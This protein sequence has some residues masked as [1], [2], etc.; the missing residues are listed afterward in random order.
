[1]LQLFPDR[2]QAG[3]D[4][5]RVDGRAQHP[6]AQQALAHGGSSRVD[7]TEQSDSNISARVQRLDQLEVADS[8]GIENQAVLALVEADAVHMMQGSALR[9]ANI[10]ENCSSG[11]CGGRLSRQAEAFKREHTKVILDEWNGVVWGEYPVVEWSFGTLAGSDSGSGGS[12]A[13]L[14]LEQRGGRCEED[15]LGL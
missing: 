12:R 5:C 14:Q 10:V 8:Y 7:A 4:F 6:G 9:G 13:S 3:I 1:M 2:I 11:G 15:F